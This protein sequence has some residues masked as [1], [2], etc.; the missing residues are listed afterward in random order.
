LGYNYRIMKTWLFIIGAPAIVLAV[1]GVSIYDQIHYAQKK[2]YTVNCTHSSEPSVAADS[3]VCVADSN[4]EY[5]DGKPYPPPWNGF[6]AW[7]EGI[8]AILL[9]ITLGGIAWQAW[10]TR[11]SAKAMRDSIRL[12]RAE[13]VVTINKERPY[14]VVTAEIAGAN[15]FVLR[16]KNEGNT[17]ARIASVWHVPIVTKRGQNMEIPPDEKTAESLMQHLPLLLPPK[18]TLMV[19]KWGVTEMQGIS[20]PPI[21]SLDFYVRIRYFNTLE[22]EQTQAYETRCLYWAIPVGD[23]L[24]IPNPW[25][26]EYNT[27]T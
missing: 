4:Q 20:L 14:L 17:P 8:T 13:M 21:S 23:R 2:G 5:D 1:V 25:H 10:E 12:Q 9:A 27:W 22:S 15:E 18:G 6:L 3:L 16:A 7:P 24:P 26:P 11:Q 19:L